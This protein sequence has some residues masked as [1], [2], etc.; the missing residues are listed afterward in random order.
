MIKEELLFILRRLGIGFVMIFL[1][2]SFSPLI[3]ASGVSPDFVFLFTF[4][5][6]VK[7]GA[8]SG[9]I[10]GFLVGIGVDVYSP[11]NIG[12]TAFALVLIGFL[13]GLANEKTI[14][15]EG[16]MQL[17]FLFLAAISY[18]VILSISSGVS[19]MSHK[20]AFSKI[21]LFTSIYTSLTGAVFMLVRNLLRNR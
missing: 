12:S 9:T 18:S 13:A 1:Q 4:F 15:M 14:R 17:L 6:A 20:T 21:I 8:F 19:E 7:G 10:V 11:E 3:S 2:T 5:T 16:K